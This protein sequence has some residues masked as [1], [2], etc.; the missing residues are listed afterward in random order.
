[1]TA[2][3]DEEVSPGYTAPELQWEKQI[4]AKSG[5]DLT[6]ITKANGRSAPFSVQRR[7]YEL[8]YLL[9]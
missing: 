5:L 8:I 3:V 7:W 4:K 1:V 2:G 9:A 6:H